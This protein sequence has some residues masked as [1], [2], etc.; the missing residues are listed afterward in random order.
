MSRNVIYVSISGIDG[1]GKSVVI[2]SLKRMLEGEGY[3]CVHRWM[4][5]NHKFVKPVHFFAR[6]VF[7]T[8]K[9]NTK[10]GVINRHEFFRCPSLRFVYLPLTW[11]DSWINVKW[12]YKFT[13]TSSADVVICDR[14]VHDIII[15]L[16]VKFSDIHLPSGKWGDRFRSL[17]PP[18]T[19][20]YLL[21]R[22]EDDIIHSRP[23]SAFDPDFRLR[24]ALYQRLPSEVKR[25]INR[26][27]V[28]DVAKVIMNDLLNY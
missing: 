28:D 4:R 5:Y 6:L 19:R 7:L 24:A 9:I 17:L 26:G 25:V 18:A 14:W 2:E 3:V 23:E 10:A 16:A 13:I 20:S 21:V 1:S 22:A 8:N 12:L 11:L 15:D 27:K